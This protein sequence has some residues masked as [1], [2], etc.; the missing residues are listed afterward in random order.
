MVKAKAKSGPLQLDFA[1]K[2]L[3]TIKIASAYRFERKFL[4][5]RPDG[6]VGKRRLYE[7]KRRGF[8]SGPLQLDF[9]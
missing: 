9:A 1:Y 5:R 8:E 2:A 7:A 3:K 4:I 6:R